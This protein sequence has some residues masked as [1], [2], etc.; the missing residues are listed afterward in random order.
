MSTQPKTFL[1]PEQYL[2]IEREAEYK[3]EY[4]QGEMFA[5]A[6]AGEAHNVLV[7][8]LVTGL[9]NHLRSRPCRVYSN[10]MRVRVSATGLYTYPDVVVVC[11]ERRFLDERRDTLLNPSLLIEVLSPSTEAYDRGKK[12][13]HY[14]SIESLR[15]YLLVASDRVHVD[16]YTR[17]PDGR[18]LLTSADRLED[19]LDLQSVGCRLALLD[20]YEKTDLPGSQPATA[21]PGSVPRLD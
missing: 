13:E 1:T 9:N 4:F 20:L 12:F 3:S 5:M 21:E 8:N 11:G 10:D 2:E 14:R 16:L 6:G 17:Q 7:G 15:E 19:S 18:W